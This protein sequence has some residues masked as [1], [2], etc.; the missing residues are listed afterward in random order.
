ML[1]KQYE[2]HRAGHKLPPLD[3]ARYRLDQPADVLRNDPA[4]WEKA[5][6]NAKAQLEHQAC[7]F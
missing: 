6:D 5:V 1:Q 7:D 4:A 3:V 2:A